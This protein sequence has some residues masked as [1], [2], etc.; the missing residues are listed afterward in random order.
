MVFPARTDNKIRIRV[1]FRVEAQEQTGD[2][3]TLVKLGDIEQRIDRYQ[4]LK[5]G[6]HTLRF[7]F[8]TPKTGIM[9]VVVTL[10]SLGTAGNVSPQTAHLET[11]LRL[12]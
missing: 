11:V 8:D 5:A 2:L 4:G 3:Q 10:D 9:P 6:N 7:S 1:R 12:Q